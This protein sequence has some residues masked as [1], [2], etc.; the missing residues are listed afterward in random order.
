MRTLTTLAALAALVAFPACTSEASS[1]AGTYAVTIDVSG[2]PAA[3]AEMMSKMMKP[4]DLT[5]KAD[6]T[7]NVSM[8][9]DMLGQK[10]TTT[11]SGTWKQE[12]GDI[13]MTATHEDG[14]EKPEPETKR[15][16]Y[17]NGAFS[18]EMDEG[19]QKMTMIM[20]KK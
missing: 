10:Q 9:I 12:G 17:K 4:G 14:T 7:W 16:A 1:A 19:G 2:M 8:E 13:V 6:R 18:I 15:G 5:L 20:K 11:V 3:Q